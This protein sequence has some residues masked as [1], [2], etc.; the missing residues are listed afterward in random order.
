MTCIDL[1]REF[2]SRYRIGLDPAAK[3][4][5]GGTH[6]PWMFTIRCQY[7]EI[8]P[9]GGEK[10]AF[11]CT[12]NII[13]RK[14]KEAF[15]DMEISNW[16]DDGEAIFIFHVDQFAEVAKFAKPRQRRQVS[17]SERR[18]LAEIGR[19]TQFSLAMRDRIGVKSEA[20]PGE[21]TVETGK[22]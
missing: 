10:L 14:L 1:K 13:R 5:P 21:A 16:S 22:S 20:T 2:G 9:Y 18:R 8:Y 12:G 11:H 4:E 6:D 15:P 3:H 17:E 19:E 7:G